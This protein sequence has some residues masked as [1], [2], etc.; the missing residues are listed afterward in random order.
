MKQIFDKQIYHLLSLLFLVPLIWILAHGEALEGSFLGLSTQTWLILAVIL[1][2]LHQVYVLL[3]WR[4][5]LHFQW[6]TS[7][8]GEK[9]FLI[10]GIGFMLLFLSRPVT[11]LALAIGSRGSFAIPLWLN[12]PLILVF[13]GISFYMGYSFVKYFGVE[14]ALGMDHF[15]PE[16]YRNKPF[17]REGIFRW[18]ANAMYT[19]AFLFLWMIALIFQSQAALLGALF[20]HLY[21]W[22]HYFFTEK[23]DMEAIYGK[24]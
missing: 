15:R 13:L 19:Y 2:I 7:A 18:S 23:P 16:E 10:W 9:A 20:N 22:V 21:I 14:R 8:F 5:E 17:V 12:L 3:L 6:L 4:G 1:P 11:I 24:R